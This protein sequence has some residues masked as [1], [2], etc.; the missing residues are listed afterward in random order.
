MGPV[1]TDTRPVPDVGPY[2]GL[3]PT[4]RKLDWSMKWGVLIWLP[5]LFKPSMAG[6]RD[7]ALTIS[8]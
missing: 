8:G 5:G 7:Q 3:D 1:I 6:E 4:V 2:V